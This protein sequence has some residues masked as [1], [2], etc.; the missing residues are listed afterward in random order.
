MASRHR[1]RD[2]WN[3]ARQPPRGWTRR[4]G[5]S[6]PSHGPGAATMP[7]RDDAP[8]DLLFGLLALQN[9]MITRDQLVAAFGV[10]TGASGR[11]MA[12]ILLEQGALSAS[13]HAL[14]DALPAEHLAVHGSDPEA[15]L[16]ALD[17]GPSMLETLTLAG[18]TSLEP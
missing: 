12:E 15:S 3:P 7:R 6:R 9:G 8:R 4:P 17:V 16:A 2:N 5:S 18:I 13:R 1:L 10:W 14:I 11:P